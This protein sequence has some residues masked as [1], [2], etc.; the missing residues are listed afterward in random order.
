M[1]AARRAVERFIDGGLPRATLGLVYG[2]RRIGK[3]TLLLS[4][5]DQRDGFYWEA[6]RSESSAQL[7]DLGAALGAHL[8]V[9]GPVA[10]ASW[11]EAVHRLLDLFDEARP[12]VI[13]EFGHLVAS[14][15]EL[16][17]LLA[18]ALGPAARRGRRSMVRLVLCGS[19]IAVMRMLLAGNEPLRG[20]AELELVMQADDFRTAA[21][22]LPNPD[23]LATA[24]Q[25]HTVIGGVVGYATDMV[26]GDLPTSLADVDRWIVDRVVSPA[27]VLHREAELL[28]AED[29]T[30]SEARGLTHVGVLRAIA[31]GRVTA[32][33]ISKRLGR[34]VSNLAPTLDRLV[35]AGFV[36]RNADPVR[37]RRPSY[38]LADP[39]LL[40][41]YAVLEG[42]RQRLRLSDP[43]TVWEREMR[44]AFDAQVRGPAFEAIAREW[45]AR[46]ADDTTLGGPAVHVGPS[47]V[48]VDGVQHEVDVVV[49]GDGHGAPPSERPVLALGEAK[50]GATL[51]LRDLARLERVR[52]ALGAKASG[53]QLL[54]VGTEQHD[55]LRAAGADRDDVVLVDLERLYHGS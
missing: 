55:E 27:A 28:V 51:D 2:R 39:F 21:T 43:G 3:T 32:G 48:S 26:A 8:G 52:G 37:A 31:T 35:D 12:V 16:P 29:P 10:L 53:A 41:N 5:V 17:S 47:V 20:R 46:F 23:D 25:V 44:P 40:F 45:T 13:D 36:H 7:A 38:A 1:S 49:A 6:P 18:R 22:R 9:G 30:L 19:A 14:T 50:A 54:L 42:R 4:L 24:V 11:D 34:P 15:P 33:A